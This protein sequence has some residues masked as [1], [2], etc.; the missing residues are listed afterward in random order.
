MATITKRGK[1]FQARVPYYAPDG[2]RKF[3]AKTFDTQREAKYWASKNE[4]VNFEDG[5]LYESMEPLP[6]YFKRWYL[7]Y[8]QPLVAPASMKWY[9][10][11]LT[12]LND[13]FAGVPIS[14]ITHDQYQKFLNE[15]GKDRVKATAV[16]I[17]GQIRM[18]V[19]NAL[20][21]NKIRRDFTRGA[22]ATGSRQSRSADLKYLNAGESERVLASVTKG[23]T[24]N[25]VTNYMIAT[26]LYTGARLAEIGGLT[27]DDI[28][29]T[30]K[31]IRI[32]K[33][34]DWTQPGHFKETKNM[35]SHRVIKVNDELL[36]LF[37]RLKDQQ[38][39]GLNRLHIANP[40]GLLFL[41]A[42]GTVP[43]SSGVN[44]M[45]RKVL[46]R[47]E[48]RPEVQDLSFHGL[49]HTHAS[50]LLFKGIS[51]YYISKRLG[52]RDIT[53]TLSIYSH[54]LNE[55][56]N[57]ESNKTL[58]ALTAMRDDGEE[59]AEKRQTR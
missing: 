13:H 43:G 15:I 9:E 4:V 58:V 11:T 2:T 12:I 41:N 30:F 27:W 21:E 55:L 5:T 59:E 46:K 45:L 36:T 19:N 40:Q 57:E 44:K 33:T 17:N 6:E 10:Y 31:T 8:K 48:V 7:T 22:V 51:V 32:N 39:L 50:Y 16:R 29:W 14:K 26:A 20:D 25:T 38:E 56:E 1:R 24:L 28:S 23:P 35:Q 37:K 54:V 53:T 52:H 3:K 49:R 34:Y 42:Q 18:A 47:V